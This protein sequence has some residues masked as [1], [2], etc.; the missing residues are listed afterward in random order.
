MM[1]R[2]D[3]TASQGVERTAPFRKVLCGIDGSR[4]AASAAD[5]A[6]AMAAPD[7]EVTF[8]TC[9]WRIGQG[10]VE[11]ATLD[12]A[13]AAKATDAA[14]HVAHDACVDATVEVVH[15]PDP[16]PVLLERAAQYDLLVLGS[17]GGSRAAGIALGST[18]SAALHRADVPVLLSR[19]PAKGQTLFDDVLVA[20]DATPESQRL[21]EVAQRV[22]PRVGR[23]TIIHVSSREDDPGMHQ[24]LVR[25]YDDLGEEA[26]NRVDLRAVPGAAHE[27]IERAARDDRATLVVLGSRGLHGLRALGSVSERVAH[28]VPCSVLVLRGADD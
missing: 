11:K 12:P 27:E 20:S 23:L 8:I 15:A 10:L 22:L 19:H 4:A 16:T 14:L 3:P 6:I 25:Q 17:H 26:Q 9:P 2:A 7:G 28:R 24:R 5:D 1:M 18:A 21:V 13:R